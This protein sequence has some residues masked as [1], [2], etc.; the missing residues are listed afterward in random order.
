[1]KITAEYRREMN[2]NYLIIKPEE[3]KTERYTEKM[4]LENVI[5]GL[6]A[7]H[8]KRVDGQA[9]FYY[10]ITSKQPLDRVLGYRNLNG[11]EIYRLVSDLLYTLKQL[12]RYLLD[13]SRLCLEPEYIYV[14]PESFQCFLCLI[15]GY[16]T[17]FMEAFRNLTTY[18]LNHIS[19]RDT[20]AVVLAF[21]IFQE[22]RKENFGLDAIEQVIRAGE[23]QEEGEEEQEE[24]RKS[25]S[26]DLEWTRDIIREETAVPKKTEVLNTGHSKKYIYSGVLVV[27]LVGLAAA[28]WI[29][30][31]DLLYTVQNF[32]PMLL[33][34]VLLLCGLAFA[35]SAA[36]ERRGGD[37]GE[38][39]E[40]KKKNG[41]EES[42][43][44]RYW[45]DEDRG[46]ET[47]TERQGYAAVRRADD[48]LGRQRK[49]ETREEFPYQNALMAEYGKC[50]EE[51]EQEDEFQ[52]VLLSEGEADKDIRRLIPKKGGEEIKIRY[53][54]FII[55]K[56]GNLADYCL[57]SPGVSRLHLRIDRTE[58]GFSLTDLNSTNGTKVGERKL[59]ANET[60]ELRVGETIEIAGLQ[61]QFM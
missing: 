15:P 45:E 10:D 34:A 44:V 19:H 12:E 37:D 8:V 3:N 53:F 6:L 20:K 59:E 25:E 17:D 11:E 13:E 35:V 41:K 57:E 30:K 4:L 55:G 60:C 1:M 51:R 39:T 38:G 18:L 2:R 46:L 58:N 33:A 52:T 49:P 23:Y 29:Q 50:E 7:F 14:E 24:D 31:G 27:L 54:P 5:S 56:N 43:E 42:W 9:Q 40:E 48:I 36:A 28:V 26:R 16:R 32:W 47:D 21:G 22:S 61:F